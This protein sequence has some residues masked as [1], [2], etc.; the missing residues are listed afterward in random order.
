MWSIRS[1]KLL[2]RAIVRRFSR[3][4][5]L[6]NP[7]RLLQSIYHSTKLSDISTGKMAQSYCHDKLIILKN[8]YQLCLIEV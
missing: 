2:Y 4:Q 7:P 1:N 8:M 5:Y 3:I 6:D